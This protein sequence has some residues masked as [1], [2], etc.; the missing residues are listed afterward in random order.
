MISKGVARIGRDSLPDLNVSFFERNQ[1]IIEDKQ[2]RSP[3]TWIDVTSARVNGRVVSKESK[4]HQIRLCVVSL[5][6]IADSCGNRIT[7]YVA[8]VAVPGPDSI[9]NDADDDRRVACDLQTGDDRME[10]ITVGRIVYLDLAGHGPIRMGHRVRTK[11]D[12][13][14]EER[15]ARI[16]GGSFFTGDSRY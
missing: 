7:C 14:S 8:V 3:D 5:A 1:F 11:M 15:A 16:N 4:A 9:G 12:S 10:N 2:D 13:S 6:I